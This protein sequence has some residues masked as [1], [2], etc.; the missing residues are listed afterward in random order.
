MYLYP[1]AYSAWVS[2]YEWD[3][4]MPARWVGVANYRALASPEFLEVVTNTVTYSVGVVLLSQAS[5]LA[6]AVLLNRRA[7]N[8]AV[9]AEDAAVPGLGLEPGATAGAV[10]EELAGVR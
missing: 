2:F 3:L 6:L 10:I 7:R 9:G 5:G 8:S 4:A 1:V